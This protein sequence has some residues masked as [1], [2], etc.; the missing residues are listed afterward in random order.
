MQ[1]FAGILIAIFVT[2]GE[3]QHESFQ[4]GKHINGGACAIGCL[5]SS[6]TKRDCDR[7]DSSRPTVPILCDNER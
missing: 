3:L 1:T 2:I 6:G 7:Y 4:N 5:R